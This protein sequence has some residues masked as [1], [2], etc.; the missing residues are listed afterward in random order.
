MAIINLYDQKKWH[1]DWTL[2]I[3]WIASLT[4]LFFSFYQQYVEKI[5]PCSL[6][7]WQRYI[8]FLVALLSPIGLIQPINPS[9]RVSLNFIFLIG[10]C[11]ATYH[12]LVQ[13]EWLN[14]Q[15]AIQKVESMNDFMRMLEQPKVSCANVSWKLFGLSASIYNII[16]SVFALITL[17]FNNIKRLINGRQI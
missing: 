17:N 5:E 1:Y 11:L 4:I 9:I 14:D 12:T 16:F 13:F 15:C 3:F 6:C 2:A 10:F 7:K 8:Y